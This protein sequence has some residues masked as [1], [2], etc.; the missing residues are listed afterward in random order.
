MS[1]VKFATFESEIELPFYSA[2][3]SSKLDHDKLDD[4]ARPVL[5]LYEA[6]ANV[7]PE[8]STRMLLLGNALTSN[9]YGIAGRT[10]REQVA[11]GFRSPPPGAIR[12]EGILKNVNTIEDFKNIDKAAILHT[13]GKQ[14]CGQWVDSLRGPS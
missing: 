10:R 13:A 2:L 5:G 3:F 4:S 7:E 14:V 11:D 1:L 6:R 9:Q 12:A 8:N